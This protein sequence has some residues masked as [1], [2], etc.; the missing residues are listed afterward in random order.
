M[1]KLITHLKIYNN[2]IIKL[3]T[4]TGIKSSEYA[5]VK[6]NCIST[7]PMGTANKIRTIVV[8]SLV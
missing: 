1:G 8:V 4:C 6:N 3:K 5:R 2:E 7:L